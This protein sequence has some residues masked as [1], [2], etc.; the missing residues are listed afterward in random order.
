MSECDHNWQDDGDNLA[1]VCVKC[2]ESHD[3][4]FS[5]TPEQEAAFRKE[6]AEDLD[7][8]RGPV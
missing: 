3:V 8:L 1:I 6:I 7:G 4:D 5:L 2:G